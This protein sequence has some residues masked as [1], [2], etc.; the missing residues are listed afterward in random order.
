ML[1]SGL[2]GRLL[3]KVTPVV[4]GLS[5]SKS[6]GPVRADSQPPSATAPISTVRQ[7]DIGRRAAPRSPLPASRLPLYFAGVN[8]IACPPPGASTTLRFVFESTVRLEIATGSGLSTQ[9]AP[10]P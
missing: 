8:R 2:S 7:A 1:K 5:S 9:V 6:G 10:G 3:A 4:S